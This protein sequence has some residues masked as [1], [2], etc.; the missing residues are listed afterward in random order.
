MVRLSYRYIKLLWDGGL[1]W[2]TIQLGGG[3]GK[4]CITL[5]FLLFG[6]LLMALPRA[7]PTIMVRSAEYYIGK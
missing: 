5:L 7:D 6:V 2:Q 4:Y 1:L 3:E